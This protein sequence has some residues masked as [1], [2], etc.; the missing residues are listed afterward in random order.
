MVYTSL[1]IEGTKG[2]THFERFLTR[3]YSTSSATCFFYYP[4]LL[5]FDRYVPDYHGVTELFTHDHETAISLNPE[6][7]FHLGIITQLEKSRIG[8]NSVISDHGMFD[9][10]I[11]QYGYEWGQDAA[12]VASAC[13][14][15]G[16]F[17]VAESI[18]LN[19]LIN[20]TNE[21]GRIAESSRFRDGELA[22]LNAN[23]AVLLALRDYVQATGDIALVEQNWQVIGDIASL[24]L[25]ADNTHQSGL[26]HG[27]RDLWER[28]PWMGLQP[29]FDVATNTLCAEGLIA[30]AE[31][32]TS[33][34]SIQISHTWQKAG[35]MMRHAIIHHTSLSFVEDEKVIHRRLLDGSVQHDM[36]P[37]AEYH[38]K[39]YVPYLPNETTETTPHPCSP[40]SVSALPILYGIVDPVSELARTTLDHLHE[41]LWNP[42]GVGGYGRSPLASDPDSPGPWPFVTAW[43]AETEL[44]AG[45]TERAQETTEWL[46]KMAGRGGSWFEYYGERQS[47][48]Y[49]PVGII[50]W[51]W[52]QYILLVVRGWMGIEFL[53]NRLRIAPRLVPY[54]HRFWV[55]DHYLDIDVNGLESARI[56]GK[57]VT[58]TNQGVEISLPL[59]RDSQVEF[60]F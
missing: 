60:S 31:L 41:H 43:M 55:G 46:L 19:I 20:L 23:G 18:L 17:E 59:K 2:T 10:S 52:A 13:C 54:Q 58:L 8:I 48:P 1:S 6:S 7:D 36:I 56:D 50:V 33:V 30:A 3:E 35:E 29:G 5:P 45:L 26:I 11:W 16:D 28:L 39:R 9:A 25:Q 37:E 53:E 51:G 38:D 44:K 49:P 4:P 40:D 42:T 32:A 22:E 47:P 24:L 21:E 34:D 12:I 15:S 57:S 27:R 14:Y